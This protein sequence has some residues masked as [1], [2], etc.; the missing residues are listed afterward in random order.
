MDDAQK[1]EI[2][3]AVRGA[4][5]E[6]F[7]AASRGDVAGLLS[8]FMDD[9]E[10][11][12]IEN[13]VLR[14]SRRAFGERLAEFHQGVKLEAALEE[15]RVFP[16]SAEA[17]LTVGVYRYTASKPSGDAI[18]GR[19]AFSYVYVKQGECWRIK[20]AHES[21]TVRIEK[22]SEERIRRLRR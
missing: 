15:A 3:K 4:L 10:L 12:A 21:A 2:E 1:A 17:A 19:N 18:E 5:A 20:H 7:Q 6:Y 8:M 13:G 11:T 9:G 14:S 22:R 16:L